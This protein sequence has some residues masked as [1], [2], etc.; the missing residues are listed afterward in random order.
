MRFI[1]RGTIA[2]ATMTL[3]A[4]TYGCGQRQPDLT[5]DSIKVVVREA[6][7]DHELESHNRTIDSIKGVVRQAL[8]ASVVESHNRTMKYVMERVEHIAQQEIKRLNTIDQIYRNT[9]HEISVVPADNVSYFKSLRQY[10][11]YTLIDIVE[12]PSVFLSFRLDIDYHYRVFRTKAHYR[13]SEGDAARD[14]AMAEYLFLR[15]NKTGTTSLSY[16]LDYELEWT[17]ATQ[18]RGQDDMALKARATTKPTEQRFDARW[19]S[20]VRQR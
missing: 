17:G 16:T 1:T 15:T 14:E 12:L 3:A 9:L 2:A 7:E 18:Q 10:N 11:S 20:R 19:V 13:I 8:D 5:A 6:L 4:L